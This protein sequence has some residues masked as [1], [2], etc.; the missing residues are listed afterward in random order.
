MSRHV[1]L[2]ELEGAFGTRK[3]N[4]I[5]CSAEASFDNGYVVEL[6]QYTDSFGKPYYDLGVLLADG[7]RLNHSQTNAVL[8]AI[9]VLPKA[10][11]TR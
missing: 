9:K 11:E 5:S 7:I 1:V 2:D 8:A 4:E 6:E 10:E 3:P